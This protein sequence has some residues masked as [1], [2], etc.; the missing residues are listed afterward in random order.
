MSS[1]EG[2]VPP[3]AGRGRGSVRSARDD[4]AA[5]PAVPQIRAAVRRAGR[6]RAAG[7]RAVSISGS[8]TR[9][10]GRADP[11]AA[12][13]GGRGGAS[14]SRSSSTRSSARSAGRRTPQWAAAPLDQRRQDYF[15]LLRQVPAITELSQ[16]DAAGQGAAQGVAAGDGRRSA[17]AQDFSQ[18]AGLYSGPRPH[19]V[20]FSPVYFR[21]ESE[22]YMTHGDGPQ[23]PQCRGHG[24]RDQSE[25]DLGRHHRAEDRAGRLCL[26]RRRRRP[27][28]RASR[29]QPGAARHRPVAACRRSRRRSR[30]RRRRAAGSG[31]R[32]AGG[33]GR[34]EHRPASRC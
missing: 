12:G 15:R 18:S 7:Q 14:A 11:P 33:R 2:I 26:C 9:K 13:E 22:P 1:A 5:P 19:R 20:W 16:L 25:A 6:R 8:P 4:A 10:Q 34:E 23:R 30:K 3:L 29:H 27:A 17:A 32:R 21:K 31:D 24:R 28:D